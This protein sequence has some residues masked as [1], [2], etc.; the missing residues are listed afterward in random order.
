MAVIKKANAINT[1]FK[2]WHKDK[3]DLNLTNLLEA[4]RRRIVT[5]YC[6]IDPNFEDIA[7]ETVLCI[8][9]A[10]PGYKGQGKLK[11]FNPKKGDFASYCAMRAR[12]IRI[13]MERSIHTLA[14]EG[15]SLERL[16][17]IEQSLGY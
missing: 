11:A 16:Q 8:W 14:I 13:N 3:S 4:V 7:Q 12:T 15:D 1:L 5:R 17:E 9:R 2:V 10:L 6:K